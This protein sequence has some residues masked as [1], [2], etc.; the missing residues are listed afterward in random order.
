MSQVKK[1]DEA[2]ALPN[3]R[4]FLRNFVGLTGIAVVAGGPVVG[5]R[6]PP[7]DLGFLELLEV[8]AGEAP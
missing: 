6:L 1:K 3:R 7:Q 4:E 5:P 8:E 2:T